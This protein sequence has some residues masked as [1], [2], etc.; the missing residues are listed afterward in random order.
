MGRRPTDTPPGDVSDALTG[1]LDR[2]REAIASID[3][4][5]TA[6]VP[7]LAPCGITGAVSEDRSISAPSGDHPAEE[8]MTSE[9]LPEG[10]GPVLA[11]TRLFPGLDA[12]GWREIAER[13]Q[14]E[15]WL[16]IEL[17]RG[18]CANLRELQRTIEIMARQRDTDPLTGLANRRAFT[19]HLEAELE[20]ARRGRGD[21]SLVIL[22]IDHFKSIN[23][24]YGHPCGDEVLLRLAAQ[25]QSS[26]RL[27]DL[28]AR[29]GGEEFALVLPGASTLKAQ[30]LCERILQRFASTEM[31][32]PGVPPFRV[33]FS[34]G[35]ATCSA[36]LICPAATLIELADKALYEAKQAGRN[37]ILAHREPGSP[38]AERSTLVQSSEKQFLFSGNTQQTKS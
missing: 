26:V 9:P 22:D 10:E 6:G 23:D 8:S 5:L 24:S 4:A 21:L 20:R 12:R 3:E 32:C 37:R 31:E 34:G 27:Y 13:H 7:C 38:D 18:T 25:L 14:L 35:V 33:T 11:V 19:R 2:L 29:I 28:A 15:G 1:E 16:P 30:A 36:G 17:A